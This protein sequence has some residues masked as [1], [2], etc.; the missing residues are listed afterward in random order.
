[1]GNSSHPGRSV[2]WR[3]VSDPEF[4]RQAVV[5]GTAGAVSMAILACALALARDTTGHDW[6][7]AVRITVADFLIR[8]GFDADAQ[9]EYRNADGEVEAVSRFGLTHTFE[10]RWARQDIL[11][12][13]WEGATLGAL[14]GF[15]GALLCLVLVWRFVDERRAQR[16][17]DE[18]SA[19]HRF[20]AQDL[21]ASPNAKPESTSAPARPMS[22]PSPPPPAEPGRAA[23]VRRAP[24]E[25]AR[26]A[27]P[28]IAVT[29]QVK[30]D[31][32]KDNKTAPA[33][34]GRRKRDYGRWV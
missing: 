23:T 28:Q 11:D 14:S 6:Y 12:A 19:T 31:T 10:A 22:L 21:L 18:S 29:R 30:P 24:S 13:A 3:V 1:M 17:A 26:P 8:A 27:N 9:V 25:P 2:A 15:G 7:A 32:G 20:E 16:P 4:W 34:P 5:A 33:R